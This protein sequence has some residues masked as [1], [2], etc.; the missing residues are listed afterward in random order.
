MASVLPE[1]IGAIHWVDK[2][3]D[4]SFEG[5]IV[6]ARVHSGGETT[7]YRSTPALLLAT[8]GN[9]ARAYV[10]FAAR[11]GAKVY[12]MASYARLRPIKVKGEEI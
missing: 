2:P 5:G 6:I 7:E 9:M 8:I 3:V 4:V 1:I 12:P 11:K 10:S